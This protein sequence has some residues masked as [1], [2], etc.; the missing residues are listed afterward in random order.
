MPTSLQSDTAVRHAKRVVQPLVEGV[1]LSEPIVVGLSTLSRHDEYTYAHAVNVCAVSVSIG[2]YLGLDRRAL[3]DLGVA[4]LLHDV[5]KHF[6]AGEITHD[7]EEWSPFE[8]ATAERHPLE[9][10]KLLARSTTL[11]PT[12]Y[13]CMQVALEHHVGEPGGYPKLP[14]GWAPSLLSQIVS[15]ADCFLS[16]QNRLSRTEPGV[17]PT[18]ALAKVL[19]PLAARFE[20][21]LRWALVRTVGFYPPGQVVEMDDG[22]IALVL[23]PSATDPARPHVRMVVAPNGVAVAAGHR[24]ELRPVPPERSVRRALRLPEYPRDVDAALDGAPGGAEAA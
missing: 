21:A 12:T 18:E 5:G 23:A 4:A 14:A 16:L 15:I 10:V 19:G 17:T 24:I 6:V 13:N 2:H 22:S 11:N 7:Y 9:G 8:R 1:S 20:P 3:A